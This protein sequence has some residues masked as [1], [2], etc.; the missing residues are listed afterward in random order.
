MPEG[1]RVIGANPNGCITAG[2]PSCLVNCG[3]RHTPPGVFP[4]LRITADR[5]FYLISCLVLRMNWATVGSWL[6]GSDL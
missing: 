6:T 4:S 5:L 2:W 1:N 3:R